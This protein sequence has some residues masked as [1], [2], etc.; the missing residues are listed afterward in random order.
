MLCTKVSVLDRKCKQTNYSKLFAITFHPLLKMFR[1]VHRNLMH[2]VGLLGLRN[3]R[4]SNMGTDADILV[5]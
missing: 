4:Q 5:C 2:R 3:W 1:I